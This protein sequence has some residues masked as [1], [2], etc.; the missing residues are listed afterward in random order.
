MSTPTSQVTAPAHISRNITL[1][2]T[3]ADET[4]FLRAAIKGGRVLLTPVLANGQAL[5]P[6][7]WRVSRLRA[8]SNL[9]GNILSRK[10]F[11]RG[12][13]DERVVKIQATLLA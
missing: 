2:F 13:L 5:E 6:S 8:K 12:T 7:P 9:R 1:E 10:A 3:P 4:A 11:R